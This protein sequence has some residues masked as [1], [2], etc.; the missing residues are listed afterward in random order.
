MG[1]NSA[2]LEQG[3]RG[4]GFESLQEKNIKEREGKVPPGLW[5]TLQ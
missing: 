4:T 2:I 3:G 1:N 5:W